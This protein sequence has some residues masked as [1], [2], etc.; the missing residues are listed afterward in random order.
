MAQQL[1]HLQTE[2][3][4][5]SLLRAILSSPK[6]RVLLLLIVLAQVFALVALII[7]ALQIG[8]ILQDAVTTHRYH[9]IPR[10][11]LAFGLA[12]GVRLLLL[13]VIDYLAVRVGVDFGQDTVNTL[14]NHAKTHPIAGEELGYLTTDGVATLVPYSSRFLPEIIGVLIATPALIVF[15]LIESPMAFIEITAGLAVLPVIMIVIGKST[16]ERADIQLRATRRLNALYLDILAGMVTL[17]SFR[18]AHLQENAIA[19]AAE[20]LR[21]RT[22]SVLRVAFIS[23]VSLD[24]LVAIIVALVA[25]SIGIR[26]NDATMTLATGGAVLFVVPEVFRPVRAAALQFHAT[27]D[28]AALMRRINVLLHTPPEAHTLG[29]PSPDPIP[30]NVTS[31]GRPAHGPTISSVILQDFGVMTPNTRVTETLNLTVFPGDVIVLQGESGAGKTSFLRGLAGFLP[32]IGAIGTSSGEWGSA[33]PPREVSFLPTDPGF[34]DSSLLQ[35][36]ILLAPDSRDSEVAEA[37]TLA[38]AKDFLPRLQQHVTA[39][40]TNLSAGERQ[41][42]GVARIILQNREVVLLD[43]PTAH[44]NS[45]TEQ[46]LLDGLIQWGS[47]RTLFIASH[48]ERVALRATHLVVLG[49]ER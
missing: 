39:G 11:A 31:I 41:R 45:S 40:G 13:R 30:V 28:A 43:E 4:S 16:S 48:S 37:L 33:L 17:K 26:L 6:R 21:R 3:K 14:T 27:Q 12:Y 47:E 19:H 24:L 25:V 49:G 18:K 29:F 38:S 42:L 34:M 10:A 46:Y 9:L 7:A 44:L 1:R 15:T 35:N 36:L 32:T 5:P 20:E 2:V 23:G 22:M 8:L